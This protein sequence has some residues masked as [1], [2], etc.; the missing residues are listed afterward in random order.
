MT[1]LVGLVQGAGQTLEGPLLVRAQHAF[2]ENKQTNDRRERKKKKARQR[3][4]LMIFSCSS[5]NHFGDADHGVRFATPAEPFC[6]LDL[7]NTIATF[8][9]E[10]KEKRK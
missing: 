6:T 4:I 5:T 3:I 9:N 1:E 8:E 10:E 7:L 2:L